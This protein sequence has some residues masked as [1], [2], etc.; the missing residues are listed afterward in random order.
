[1]RRC[2]F[3]CQWVLKEYRRGL[4]CTAQGCSITRVIN[5]SVIRR[6]NAGT[7]DETLRL[8]HWLCLAAH[9]MC[10]PR[11]DCCQQPTLNS[12]HEDRCQ[13]DI[14]RD[15]TSWCGRTDS[16]YRRSSA[17]GPPHRTVGFKAAAEP[18]L[19]HWL[20]L[21][22]FCKASSRFWHPGPTGMCELQMECNY[23]SAA[24]S[25]VLTT[26][27]AV[28]VIVAPALPGVSP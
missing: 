10:S 1:M 12:A 15:I 21:Q 26:G 5:V 11:T 6:T 27:I 2:L 16:T 9:E 19:R 13:S 20:P 25:A 24:A 14:G 22:R 18:G 17:A 7:A 4:R 8:T 28:A 23:Q 3:R